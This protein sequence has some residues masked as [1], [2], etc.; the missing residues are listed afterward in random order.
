M[1]EALLIMIFIFQVACIYGIYKP[2]K[3]AKVVPAIAC[4]N[5]DCKFWLVDNCTH[6]KPVLIDDL[7]MCDSEEEK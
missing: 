2:K 3:V 1:T 4:Y 7:G 5:T 6:P